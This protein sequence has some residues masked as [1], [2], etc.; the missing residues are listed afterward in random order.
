MKKNK[1]KKL[2]KQ[3]IELKKE[4]MELQKEIEYCRKEKSII[5]NAY[6]EYLIHCQTSAIFQQWKDIKKVRSQK[7][8]D[9]IKTIF[10]LITMTLITYGIAEKKTGQAVI[11]A[12]LLYLILLIIEIVGNTLINDGK[13][14]YR[15]F[16]VGVIVDLLIA[17]IPIV[18]AF[19]ILFV[20]HSINGGEFVE[21][22]VQLF[23]SLLFIMVVVLILF[24]I[25]CIVV[26]P[27][28]SSSDKGK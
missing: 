4:N 21:N 25:T 17:F 23:F 3:N 2:Q 19:I 20:N 8:L 22:N 27:I 14:E 5:A 12:V 9:G 1:Y 18:A 16:Y 11:Y 15:K 7:I 13:M 6:Y 28:K 26:G 10:N 24:I